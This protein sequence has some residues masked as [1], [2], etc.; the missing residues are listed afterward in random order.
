MG[1]DF[2][3][4]K[5]FHFS[6]INNNHRDILC[7]CNFSL[8]T[9]PVRRY[10]YNCIKN[11]SFITFEHMGNFL[12]YTIS[13]DTFY[14]NLNNSKYV[15]CPRGNALDSFRFYDTI[16]SGAIPIIVKNNFHDLPFFKNVPILFLNNESE[17]NSLTSE[18][19]NEKY[20]ELIKKRG[21]YYNLDMN[22]FLS[23]L[24]KKN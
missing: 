9:H 15:I 6:N 2:R 3:S 4:I 5:S 1:C 14:K 21:Y 8:N 12:N 20:D 19:L 11:K 7:Y 10:I 24:C 23:Y 18:L 16:Y 22:N 17:Y 13:R